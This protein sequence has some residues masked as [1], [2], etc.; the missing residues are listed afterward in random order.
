MS[1]TAKALIVTVILVAPS[2][3]AGKCHDP[4]LQPHSQ[5]FPLNPYRMPPNHFCPQDVAWPED[6][7][8]PTVNYGLSLVL[9]HFVRE[10]L[11][12]SAS[13]DRWEGLPT[14]SADYFQ[15]LKVWSYKTLFVRTRINLSGKEERLS[16]GGGFR[17]AL[18]NRSMV[19]VHS[20]HDWVRMRGSGHRYLREAGVG[21][22]VYALPG[23]YSDLSLSGNYYFPVN[24]RSQRQVGG[25]A[26]VSES[27]LGGGD[28][29]VKCQLPALVDWL[30]DQVAA[31]VHTYRVYATIHSGFKVGLSANT[32]DGMLG[33]RL[34]R[35]YETEFGDTISIKGTISL[36]FDWLAL[37]RGNMPFS[38]PYTVPQYRNGGDV[39]RSLHS[40]TTRKMDMP[41]GSRSEKRIT[42]GA[43]ISYD[44]VSFVGRFPTPSKT[45]LTVQVSLPKASY[46]SSDDLINGQPSPKSMVQD[47]LP[48]WRDRGEI[49]TDMRGEYSGQVSLPPGRYKIRIFHR[50]SGTVSNEETVIIK[51]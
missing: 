15:S 36:A 35:G 31:E 26:V 43:T 7:I 6:Y 9:P 46:Q 16:F 39:S 49:T 44:T 40:R 25:N 4:I 48:R 42:F 51:E 8:S 2:L 32:R 21:F 22:K 33:I 45:K 50:P 13:Y 24:E 28:L 30:D 27:L 1:F 11:E 23:W 3:A 34:Q 18:T 41:L 12:F 19:G 5:D 47:S 37:K 20:F 38:A 17:Q 29:Q 14:L 10:G